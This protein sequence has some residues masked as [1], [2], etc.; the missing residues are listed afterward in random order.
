V[1]V[2]E[3]DAWRGTVRL[4]FARDSIARMDEHD[5]TLVE[6]ATKLSTV[7]HLHRMFDLTFVEIRPHRR[8]AGGASSGANDGQLVDVLWSD[9]R[10]CWDPDRPGA[11][12]LEPIVR[13][14]EGTRVA[15]ALWFGGEFDAQGAAIREVVRIAGFSQSR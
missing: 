11:A 13:S 14:A 7:R 8:E 5:A 1:R 6:A 10:F 9:I 15:C 12:Q 3:V 2:F 4:L